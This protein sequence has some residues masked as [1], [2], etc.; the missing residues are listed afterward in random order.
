MSEICDDL[1]IMNHSEAVGFFNRLIIDLKLREL[2]E[3]HDP[4]TIERLQEASTHVR[5]IAECKRRVRVCRALGGEWR[6]GGA[7][8]E[9]EGENEMART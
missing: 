6:R 1:G 3:P 8:P 7:G 5:D 9:Y 4:I 2:G